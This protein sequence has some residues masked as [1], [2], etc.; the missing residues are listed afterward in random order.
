M[1][2]GRPRK[3]QE[4]LDAEMDDYWGTANTGNSGAAEPA[5]KD[6]ARNDAPAAATELD[7]IEMIE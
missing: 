5:G 2:N 3:T 1:V 7:D 4:E 6:G